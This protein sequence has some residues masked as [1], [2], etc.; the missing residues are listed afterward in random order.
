MARVREGSTKA[1]KPVCVNP[2]M[3]DLWC[4]SILA[5]AAKD[6]R[7][8]TPQDRPHARDVLGKRDTEWLPLS[9]EETVA[10]EVVMVGFIKDMEHVDREMSRWL[11][12]MAGH[13]FSR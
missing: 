4:K 2:P 1:S 8:L 10:D 12:V 5:I 6:A 3:K 7:M 13:W 9:R 11:L